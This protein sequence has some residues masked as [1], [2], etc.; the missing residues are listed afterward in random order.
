MT[1]P[2]FG[3]AVEEKGEGAKFHILHFQHAPKEDPT[4]VR[5]RSFESA[6][7][8]IPANDANELSNVSLHSW[9]PKYLS[10][11][12]THSAYSTG[13]TKHIDTSVEIP[14]SDSTPKY[15]LF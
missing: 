10:L 12:D 15:R 14:T 11:R 2:W 13:T 7:D 6:V 8:D 4:A 5:P 1:M 9:G 3:I